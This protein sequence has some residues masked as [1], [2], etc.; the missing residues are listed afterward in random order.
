MFSILFLANNPLKKISKG[1]SSALLQT[2]GAATAKKTSS[3]LPSTTIKVIAVTQEQQTQRQKAE[4]MISLE[5][6]TLIDPQ[7]LGFLMTSWDALLRLT[8]NSLTRP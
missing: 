6:L 8:G 7:L 5:S 1:P 3:T 4:V 2:K